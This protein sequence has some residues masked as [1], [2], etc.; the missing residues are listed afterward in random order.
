[1]AFR[2]DERRFWRKLLGQIMLSALIC[3]G[4]FPLLS[5][6]YT[7][8]TRKVLRVV[9]LP[10]TFLLCW[11]H[12]VMNSDNV[13]CSF[14]CRVRDFICFCCTIN[15][16]IL[17]CVFRGL[18][19]CLPK[20]RRQSAKSCGGNFIWSSFHIANLF[21]SCILL[22]IVEQSVNLFYM[23]LLHNVFTYVVF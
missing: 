14:C 2:K 18:C 9:R 23:Q 16:N 7:I 3:W 15:R 10:R 8:L 5:D 21:A 19:D 11:F 20:I 4:L 13:P 22:V 12:F 6:C 17:V 1:V